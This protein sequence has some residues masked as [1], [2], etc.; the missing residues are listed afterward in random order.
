MGLCNRK[1]VCFVAQ[2]W[3][4]RTPGQMAWFGSQDEIF[5]YLKNEFWMFPHVSVA[6]GWGL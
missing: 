3:T 1:G 2:G 5:A 6:R 4:L